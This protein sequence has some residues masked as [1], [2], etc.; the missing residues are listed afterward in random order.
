MLLVSG[1][2]LKKVSFLS[3]IKYLEFGIKEINKSY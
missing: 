3:R 2:F 1:F